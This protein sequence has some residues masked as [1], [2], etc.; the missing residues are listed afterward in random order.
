MRTGA[1]RVRFTA[2]RTA[3]GES[4]LVGLQFELFSADDTNFDG[5]CHT[6]SKQTKKQRTLSRAKS[7][8]AKRLEALPDRRA[9][10]ELRDCAV[11]QP[12]TSTR[13]K[14]SRAS[15]VRGRDQNRAAVITDKLMP[16][17]G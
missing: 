4:G 8:L 10:G 13:L 5:E 12:P 3:V 7:I 1:M 14:E 17:S 9:G 11:R 2:F 15:Q 6:G 16:Q